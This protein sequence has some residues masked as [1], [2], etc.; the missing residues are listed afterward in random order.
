MKGPFPGQLLT[1]VAM[2]PNNGIYPLAYAIAEAESKDS[3]TWFLDLL[4]DDLELP[5]NANFT[6]ISDRQKGIIPA[7]AAVFPS[8]EHRYCVRHIHQ[9]FRLQ[10]R[11]KAY[12]D[13]LW[14]IATANTV[15][16]FQD[17]MEEMRLMNP[18]AHHYLSQIPAVHWTRSH[19]SG[20]AKTEVLLNNL[21][22]VF[23]ARLVDGRDKPIIS[24][25]EYVREY[26]MKRIVNVLKV[27]A[28]TDGV[29]TPKAAEHFELVKK[30]A[31]NLIVQ[32]NGGPKYQVSCYLGERYGE[33][34]VVDVIER[35]CTC[36]KWEIRGMPCTHA[37]ATN[38]DMAANGLKVDIP[39]RW[40]DECYW[41]STWKKVYSYKI[42]PING[43]SMWPRAHCSTKLLEPMYHKPVGRPRKM[44]RKD[45]ME[46]EDSMVKDG[47]LSRKWKTV[48]CGSCGGKGHNKR[49][50]TGQGSTAAQSS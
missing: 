10:W 24:A 26:C 20:R 5:V 4:R 34:F 41:L 21:C 23:N 13:M 25:L 36:R 15:Q 12:K 1:A 22:E 39:E 49:R 18:D 48:T 31:A 42:G 47:K 11:G 38:W 7:I 30:H 6:F 3:W 33:Q 27:I 40:V 43:R 45:E 44:R 37:V 2:D 50:C 17:K 9:N 14:A 16:Q 28:K 32:W 8:A 19:F 29:L 35:T 46:K